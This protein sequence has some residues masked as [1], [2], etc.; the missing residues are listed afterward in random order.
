MKT[1]EIKK[2]YSAPVATLMTVA[3]DDVLTSSGGFMGEGDP[4]LL[5]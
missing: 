1:I 2:E 4:I 3:C 5:D